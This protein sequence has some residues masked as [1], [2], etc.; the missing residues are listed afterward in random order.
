MRSSDADGIACGVCDFDSLVP[1]SGYDTLP[2][3]TS[4]AKPWPSGGSLAVCANC[5]GVQKPLTGSFQREIAD[6]YAS[7]EIYHQA[8]GAE[9][10]IFDLSG[11]NAAPR[12]EKLLAALGGIVS[13]PDTGSM[14]DFGCGPG[15]AL[16]SFA[17]SYPEWQLNGAELSTATLGRLKQIQGFK[18]LYTCAVKDIPARFD[19]ITLIHSLEHVLAPV[20]TLNDLRGRLT[21]G[22]H[23]FVQVPDCARNPYDLVIADHLLHFTLDTLHRAGER[24]GFGTAFSSD[25]LLVKELSWL[26]ADGGA[27]SSRSIEP[28]AE[29]ERVQGFVEWL[30]DQIA[31][32]DR[33]ALTGGPFGIFGTSI[34]ATWLY[35]ALANRVDFFVDEDRQRIGKTHMGLP[36]LAPSE[37]PNGAD[38]F[39]PLI[40]EVASAVVRRLGS[41][42]VKFRVP[43]P[44]RAGGRALR[45]MVK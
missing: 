44:I 19:L 16:G 28:A 24:A 20:E 43:Q 45:A 3:V 40:P 36:I 42:G 27:A 4:D 12:S 15:G 34:S 14:L 32:A 17:K 7:Y 38:V 18:S 6:I 2:R 25:S 35:T 1:I 31:A 22:G 5:G 21:P 9:Q 29:L 11:T 33:L 30:H 23:V 8:D 13:L 10:P 39:V 37:V 41:L 26:G